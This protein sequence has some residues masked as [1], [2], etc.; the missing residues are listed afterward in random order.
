MSVSQLAETVATL[1][2]SSVPLTLRACWAMEAT[3]ASTAWS[4]PRLSAMGLAPAVT[5]LRPSRTIASAR[6]T[7]VV[8]P[9]PATSEVL[10]ATWLAILAPMF[11]KGLGRSIS[12]ETVTPSLVTLGPP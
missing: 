2:R 5:F 4:M 11:S 1:R 6:T 7:A 8:V 10:L 9:S 3:A 12:L